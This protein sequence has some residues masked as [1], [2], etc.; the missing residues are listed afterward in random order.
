MRH[1]RRVSGGP[2]RQPDVEQS[3]TS[4]SGEADGA[5]VGISLPELPFEGIGLN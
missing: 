5:R 3:M 2:D 1:P 4:A